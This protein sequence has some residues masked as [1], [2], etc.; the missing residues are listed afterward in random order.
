MHLAPPSSKFRPSSVVSYWRLG[1]PI[2][3]GRWYNIFR[4]APKLSANPKR[5]DYVLKLVNPDLSA[6]Q[7]SRAIDRLSREAI[8]TEELEHPNVIRLLDAELDQPPFFLVQPWVYGRSLDRMLSAE[9]HAPVNRILWTIRQIAEG[10]RAAHDRGRVF[11]GL[12]PSHVLLGKTGRVTLLG[13][14]QCHQE[15]EKVW[16]PNDQLQTVR[17]MAPECFTED[18]VANPASDVY[19][20]GAMIYHLFTM[21]PPFQKQSIAELTAD[22]IEE[23]PE[24]LIVRQPDCPPALS[25]LVKQMLSSDIT[26]RP[27]FREAMNELIGVEIN[28]LTDQAIIPL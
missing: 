12:E 5:F 22:R 13:W 16:F 6:E 15:G 28:H 8:A 4:A 23:I 18:Y 17:Y 1:A 21:Q 20:L 10:I 19:S 25:A 14:S 24:D 11:L 2:T 9:R 27:T 7:Q 26:R 3:S